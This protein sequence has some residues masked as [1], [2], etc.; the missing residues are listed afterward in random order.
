MS[1][2]STEQRALNI[3]RLHELADLQHPH[4]AGNNHTR[5]VI[6]KAFNNEKM[7][8]SEIFDCGKYYQ[9][10][11]GQLSE[12]ESNQ[13]LYSEYLHAILNFKYQF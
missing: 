3:K 6:D 12:F 4:L 11:L 2:T 7:T 9:R 8:N 10:M 1:R 13:G 5:L